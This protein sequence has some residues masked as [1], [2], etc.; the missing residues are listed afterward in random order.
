MR[1]S[2][3]WTLILGA[4]LALTF[5]VAAC[6]GGDDDS[7]EQDTTAGTPA[8]GKKGGKLVALWAGDTD[9]IDP[10]ITYSQWGLPIIRATQTT[11]YRPKID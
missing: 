7:S 2:V 4:L 9:N 10:G 6:G 5:G 3:Q 11:L 1:R 8:E